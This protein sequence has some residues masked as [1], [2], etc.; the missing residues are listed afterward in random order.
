LDFIAF[1]HTIQQCH[2]NNTFLYFIVRP[3]FQSIHT[4]WLKMEI[5]IHG[6]VHNIRSNIRCFFLFDLMSKKMLHL[7][8]NFAITLSWSVSSFGHFY[9]N[10]IIAYWRFTSIYKTAIVLPLRDRCLVINI[11][12]S[13]WFN[14]AFQEI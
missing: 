2:F 4:S 14:V 3:I 1:F 9:N 8:R 13:L 11:L 6:S 10:I 5:N 7:L 12:L